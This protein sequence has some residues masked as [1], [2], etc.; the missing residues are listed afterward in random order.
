MAINK[1]IAII[2]TGIAPKK[3]MI[4]LA[5]KKLLYSVLYFLQKVKLTVLIKIIAIKVPSIV[6]SNFSIIEYINSLKKN[7][8]KI[9]LLHIRSCELFY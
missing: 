8:K 1:I 9:K 5:I 6:I 7:I 4:V 2:N 3:T